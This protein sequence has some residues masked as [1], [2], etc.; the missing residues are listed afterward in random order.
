MHPLSDRPN[1]CK[2]HKFSL[3]TI[4]PLLGGDGCDRNDAVSAHLKLLQKRQAVI[5]VVPAGLCSAAC[6]ADAP[7]ADVIGLVLV[8]ERL[9]AHVLETVLFGVPV[10]RILPAGRLFCGG[11]ALQRCG[12]G[13]D[14][15]QHTSGGLEVI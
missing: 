15:K 5:D 14:P 10:P 7:C 8:G 4:L 11:V 9:S 3:R 1:R 12:S 2:R 13:I 6:F